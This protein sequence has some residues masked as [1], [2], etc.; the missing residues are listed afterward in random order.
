EEVFVGGDRHWVDASGGREGTRESR[1]TV[2]HEDA[3]ERYERDRGPEDL[4]RAVDPRT[5]LEQ[6]LSQTWPVAT[7]HVEHRRSAGPGER[8][9]ADDDQEDAPGHRLLRSPFS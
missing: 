7:V 3:H 1:S 6:E 9:R 5:S 8:D 2:L 4:R